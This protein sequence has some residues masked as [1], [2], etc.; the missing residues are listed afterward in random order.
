MTFPQVINLIGKGLDLIPTVADIAITIK[1]KKNLTTSQKVDLAAQIIYTFFQGV[2]VA[3]NAARLIMPERVNL[4]CKE[5]SLDPKE[6]TFT[7]A[8]TSGATDVARKITKKIV[9][10]DFSFLDLVDAIGIVVFRASDVVTAASQLDNLSDQDKKTLEWIGAGTSIAGTAAGIGTTAFKVYKNKDTIHKASRIIFLAIKR[11]IC[12]QPN[13]LPVI[14]RDVVHNDDENDFTRNGDE[15]E[16]KHK[17]LVYRMLNW[18]FLDEIP[19]EFHEDLEFSKNKCALSGKPIRNPVGPRINNRFVTLYERKGLL[20]WMS[21]HPN[22]TPPEW[23]VNH[24][25]IRPNM[26]T[27]L[28]IKKKIED[29]LKYYEGFMRLEL[30]NN[31]KNNQGD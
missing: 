23:P 30:K 16:R 3:F 4:V 31:K 19:E 8:V 9:I 29:R 17:D 25:C 13:E 27:H 10:N 6:V 22:E 7:L 5:L 1:N 24:P 21:E 28:L 14:V 11:F 26:V 12:R 2:D 18:K 15:I 20:Q